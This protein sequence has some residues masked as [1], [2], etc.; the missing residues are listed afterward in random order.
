MPPADLAG[1]RAGTGGERNLLHRLRADQLPPSGVRQRS[2]RAGSRRAAALLAQLGPGCGVR[3][4]AVTVVAGFHFP[5]PP[6]AGGHG[7]G[8]IRAG[9]TW[10]HPLS[11]P[12]VPPATVLVPVAV[13]KSSLVVER[14]TNAGRTWSIASQVEVGAAP[15]AQ[16]PA[17]WFQAITAGDWLVAAPTEVLGTADGGRRWSLARSSVVLREPV[18]FTSL[19]RG[20]A[21]GSGLSVASATYDG[22][23]TWSAEEMPADLYSQALTGQGSPIGLVQSP[24]PSVAVAAGYAGLLISADHGATSRQSLGPTDPVDQVDFVD[25]TIG[26]ALTDNQILAD[27]R[28]RADMGA[29]PATLGGAS[30]G[31]LFLVGRGG[32][33]HGGDDLV[34]DPGRRPGVEPFSLPGGWQVKVFTGNGMPSSTCFTANGTGWAAARQGDR[35]TVLVTTDGGER[36]ATSLPRPRSPGR[37]PERSRGLRSPA[38]MW[39]SPPATASRRGSSSPS[40]PAP[41]I[42]RVSLTPLTCSFPR[43]WGR[44]GSTSCRA[45]GPMSSSDLVSPL[46]LA[47]PSRPGPA[48][49]GSCPSL[50]SCPRRRCSGSPPTTRISAVSRSPSPA[51][52]VCSGPRTTTR[53]GPRRPGPRYR[54]AGGPR[55]RR[56]APPTRGRCSPAHT[57]RRASKPAPSTP[58]TMRGRTGGWP[59]SSPGRQPGLADRGTIERPRPPLPF[60]S[61]NCRRRAQGQ[62]SLPL[63][64]PRVG[65]DVAAPACPRWR[66]TVGSCRKEA[67]YSS[68]CVAPAAVCRRC[69]PPFGPGPIRRGITGPTRRPPRPKG[70]MFG[71]G[72]VAAG[73][74]RAQAIRG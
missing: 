29:S 26:F 31:H 10:A 15:Q 17:E 48:S 60:W 44:I 4:M 68:L 27:D 8:P 2:G 54:Q 50:P 74:E 9:W 47:V 65:A 73:L 5:P 6:A 51:T 35:L 11:S 66:R 12:Q 30:H 38:P 22:G 42:C 58:P 18:Y 23:R 63:P 28:W 59:T 37:K 33:G 56:S 16:T 61:R 19:E 14:S 69:R 43:T 3:P 57:T 1:P 64:H 7:I 13:G 46:P 62:E 34:P 49:R 45:R 41:A 70:V 55:R 39:N 53:A 32:P 36:W 71:S 72:P 21:Q 40:R 52:V 25:G 24:A 20:F 67:T